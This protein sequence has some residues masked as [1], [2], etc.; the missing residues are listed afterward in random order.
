MILKDTQLFLFHILHIIPIIQWFYGSTR[1]IRKVMWSNDWKWKNAYLLIQFI[2]H[3]TKLF[4]YFST[5]LLFSFLYW[6]QLFIVLFTS[7]LLEKYF[8]PRWSF[9][10][11]K[12]K[13]HSIQDLDY[14]QDGSKHP[15]QNKLGLFCMQCRDVRYYATGNLPLSVALFCSQWINTAFLHFH[16]IFLSSF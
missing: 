16:W 5:Y 3:I 14:R 13:S 6:H 10:R 15:Y 7:S 9:T 2:R 1:Y 11:E 4:I 12:L 8:P